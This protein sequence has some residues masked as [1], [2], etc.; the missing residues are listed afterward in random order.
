MALLEACFRLKKGRQNV[1]QLELRSLPEGDCRIYAES[2]IRRRC[3]QF[4]NVIQPIS[5]PEVCRRRFVMHNCITFESHAE[6]DTSALGE[7]LGQ[8]ITSG[9]TV[10]LDGQLGA[11]KTNL[12]R[13]I[14]RG[15]GIDSELVN[16]PTFVLMQTYTGGRLSV[17][18]FDAY[19]L[20]DVDEFLAIGAEEY[21]H[22]DGI[23]CLIEWADIVKEVLPA[24]HLA[25]R[26]HHIGETSRGFQLT[27]NGPTSGQLLQAIAG[28]S[29]AQG[30]GE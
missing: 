8:A 25:I 7:C 2:G 16:S 24:D 6:R 23:V 5:I 4:G 13:S 21:L 27:A 14:C 22:D 18:H 9:L 30:V 17:L 20:G 29:A 1:S 19:R 12:V 28:L 26:I 15:L 11:G 3:W 10:G